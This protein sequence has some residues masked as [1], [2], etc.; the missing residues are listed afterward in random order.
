MNVNYSPLFL[1]YLSVHP[2]AVCNREQSTQTFY[3]KSSVSEGIRI[4][5]EGIHR[6]IHYNF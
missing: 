6:Y 1:W 5:G 3:V 2:S 4:T